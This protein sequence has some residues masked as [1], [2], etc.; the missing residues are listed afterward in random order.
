MFPRVTHPSATP[1]IAT[2]V[3]LACVKPAASV[4]S[5]PGSNSQVQLRSQSRLVTST[6]TSRA[7]P[8]FLTSS[9]HI[10]LNAHTQPKPASRRSKAPITPNAMNFL[11]R[12]RQLSLLSRASPAKPS[13]PAHANA[14]TQRQKPQTQGQRRPR[15]SSFRCNCQTAARRA[16]DPT[17]SNTRSRE[18]SSLRGNASSTPPS[19]S[20]IDRL[21]KR[22]KPLAP[23]LSR[24]EVRS[25]ASD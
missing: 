12:D 9:K 25:F 10:R 23:P 24:W 4:R 19:R 8:L 2:S 22:P 15:L 16:L 17:A 5:E 20:Q 1:V 7:L 14:Q 18:A 11:K 3:R 6:E 13:K 21:K